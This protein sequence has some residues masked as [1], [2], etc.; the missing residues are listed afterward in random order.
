MRTTPA[1]L[2]FLIL[3]LA[4]TT[5]L[6][7]GPVRTVR[8][9]LPAQSTPV[10]EH[11]AEVFARQVAQRCEAKVTTV[12]D[13]PACVELVIEP[14]IGT[15][16]FRI[17]DGAHGLIRIVGND[18][19]GL[20]YGLGKLLRSSR[21]DQRGWTP[22][23]WRG[24][25][26]P[27]CPVRGIYF[28]MHFNNFYEAAPIEEVEHYV[29]DLGLWG[30]NSLIVHFPHWQFQGFDDPQAQQSIRRLKSILRA[31][32]RLGIR[33]G[34][35]EAANDGFKSTPKELRRTPVPDAW[36]R[37]GNFGVNLC[38]SNP[39]A[40]ELLLH[41]WGRLLD[42]FAD[43]GLDYIKY[44]PYDE[45][46]CGCK[47]C[48]PWGA[49]GY[50]K[51]CRDLS[52]VTRAK[53]PRAR[54]ILSTW[55]FDSPPA[56]EWEGL[57]QFLVQDKGWVDYIQADAHED[58][59]RYPLEKGV[60]GG[61]PLLNFPEISMWGQTPWGG[62]GANPLAARLQRL[63]NQTE[64]K[65]SGGF[66]YSEGIYEDLNKV[67]CSQFYWN[68][69][70]AAIEAIKEY[71]A[72]E[73]SPDVVGDVAAA[74]EIL[75]QNHVRGRIGPSANNAHELIEVAEKKLSPQARRAWR[76]RIV[77]LRAS[78]DR[79][80]LKHQGRL[81]GEMLKGAFDELTAIYHAEN[82]HSMPVRPPQIR[83]PNAK[84]VE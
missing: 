3:V 75:E 80:L 55:T 36:G 5:V 40:H 66:P 33:V 48:W 7:A 16:G 72:F 27:V 42:A 47:E 62:Y 23:G 79:E 70:Q 84:R 76:W 21:Y 44:W 74:I 30:L 4:G 18:E 61:L 9:V 46:G 15:E 29:E 63:W 73:Y 13:A 32:R 43:V 22:G 59:P 54:F 82:V 28:A 14:G 51:L 34:L 10:V 12:G 11:I 2:S 35:V 45:G 8:L 67:V 64:K 53:L 52:A 77:A 68:P 60:P 78:I 26:V 58:F 6:R 24:T 38:P 83:V 20:L 56:G 41:N 49:K 71:V 25:S 57:A 50:L 31:A 39:K 69:N 37:H 81:E 17:L 1:A 19:P 65:L